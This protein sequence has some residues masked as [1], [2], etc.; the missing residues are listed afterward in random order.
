MLVFINS[1]DAAVESAC[2]GWEDVFTRLDIELNVTVG[3]QFHP[4]SMGS[5]VLVVTC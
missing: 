2:S 5:K 1:I 4:S 3:L